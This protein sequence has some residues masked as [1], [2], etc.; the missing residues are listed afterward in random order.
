MAQIWHLMNV[1]LVS[2][3]IESELSSLR[4]RTHVRNVS[5]INVIANLHNVEFFCGI[6]TDA[7]YTSLGCPSRQS[8]E[9]LGPVKSKEYIS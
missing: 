6:Y 1:F 5:E 8:P 3:E 9:L 7:V 2:Y 4:R